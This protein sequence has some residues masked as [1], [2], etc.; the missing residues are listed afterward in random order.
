LSTALRPLARNTAIG[1]MYFAEDREAI[2]RVIL[3]A[4]VKAASGA[5]R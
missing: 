4:L 1:V 3:A 2:A 5:R